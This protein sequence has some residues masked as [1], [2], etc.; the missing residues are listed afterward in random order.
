[1]T[2]VAT[3]SG[4]Q[5]LNALLKV[6]EKPGGGVQPIKIIKTWYRFAGVCSLRTCGRGIAARL[7]PLQV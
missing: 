4:A 6:L 2:T 5:L 1:M 7:A 3:Q